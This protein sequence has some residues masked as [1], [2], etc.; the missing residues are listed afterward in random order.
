MDDSLGSTKETKVK[1]IFNKVA[2]ITEE[3]RVCVDRATSIKVKLYGHSPE[4]DAKC[5]EVPSN[6]VFFDRLSDELHTIKNI[7][8]GLKATLEEINENL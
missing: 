5:E 6:P 8:A 4:T 1:T 7:V 2:R 3:L